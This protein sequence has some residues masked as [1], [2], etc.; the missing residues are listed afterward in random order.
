MVNFL[1]A[2]CILRLAAKVERLASYLLVIY[3]TNVWETGITYAAS[4]IYIWLGTTKVLALVFLFLLDNNISSYWMLIFS[5]TASALGMGLMSISTPSWPYRLITGSCSEYKMKCISEIQQSFFYFALVLIMIGRS[6][7]NAAMT[8][9]NYKGDVN[10]LMMKMRQLTD[11][12]SNIMVLQAGALLLA[13]WSIIFGIPSVCSLIALYHL[14]GKSWSHKLYIDKP[15]TSQVTT[16]LRVV[17]ASILNI[18]PEL[19]NEWID[20]KIDDSPLHLSSSLRFLEK[21]AIRPPI[22]NIRQNSW[23]FCSL[24]EVENTKTLVR[25]LPMGAVFVILIL[26]SSIGNSYFFA[27]A[28]YLKPMAVFG[29]EIINTSHLICVYIYTKV[30]YHEEAKKFIETNIK[31]ENKEM[32][33]EAVTGIMIYAIICYSIAALVEKSR[34]GVIRLHGISNNPGEIIPMSMFWLFPQFFLL[35]CVDASLD[36][37]IILFLAEKSSLVIKKFKVFMVEAFIGVG[38]MSVALVVYVVGKVSEKGGRL[39]WFQHYTE[40]SRLDLFYWSLT[41]LCVFVLIIWLSVSHYFNKRQHP[42][43]QLLP[44]FANTNVE[45][46]TDTSDCEIGLVSNV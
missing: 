3:L 1:E 46:Y 6:S 21:A 4:L 19:T 43:S 8:T 17:V 28:E 11:F 35:A 10:E 18:S 20:F 37:V 13:P 2:I 39:N 31:K 22:D 41:V 15:E 34:L 26:L 5:T 27:Q 7:Y 29:F 16:I 36:R 40:N 44:L 32:L 33:H 12:G 25:M 23:T 38:H 42:N 14:M 9:L 30:R 24:Q 45:M